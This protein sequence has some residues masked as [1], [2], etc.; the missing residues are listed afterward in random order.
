[1]NKNWHNLTE[2]P[3]EGSMVIIRYHDATMEIWGVIDD[4]TRMID[5]MIQAYYEPVSW[6]YVPECDL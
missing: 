1:M 4:W 5:T 6:C 3:T 2:T